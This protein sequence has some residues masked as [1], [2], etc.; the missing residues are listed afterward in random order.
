[1]IVCVDNE[2]E[3]AE[4][5]AGQENKFWANSS[6]KR[7]NH[8]S[9]YISNILQFV[10]VVHITRDWICSSETDKRN[11]KQIGQAI[12]TRPQTDIDVHLQ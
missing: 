3:G 12:S 9:R 5:L 2:D 11:R 4:L 6:A 10:A 8:V 1:M 7:L